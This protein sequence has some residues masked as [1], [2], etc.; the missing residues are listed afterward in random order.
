MPA[1]LPGSR[2][3]SGFRRSFHRGPGTV[4]SATARSES[5]HMTGD[6]W[7]L[8]L[9]RDD[10]SPVQQYS[11]SPRRL[12]WLVWS[13]VAVLAL[14]AVFTSFVGVSGFARLEARRLGRENELLRQQLAAIR[15]DVTHLEGTLG[16][17]TRRDAEMRQIAGLDPLE[18]DLLAVGVGGPGLAD[19]ESQPLYSLDSSLGESA[20]AANYDIEAL[21]R[22]ALLL[23]ESMAEATDSLEAHRDLL[24]ATPSI[25]PTA[26]LLSSRFSRARQHPLYHRAV[27]HEG[28]DISAPR[29][30]PILAAAKGK[31]T[32]AGWVSGYGQ[33]VE[34]AHG[35]GFVTRYGHASKLMVRVGQVVDRGEIIAQVGN[36]GI[37]TSSHLHYEVLVNGHAQNPLNYV[38]P[39]VFP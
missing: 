14:A 38:L 27:P 9:V 6:R 19:P 13:G 24:E 2:R 11:L 30:T 1:A 22:R 18:R 28:I 3:V 32:R 10:E 29:G 23:S 37:A 34:I 35:Y 4:L 39:E 25:L 36:S 16:D 7:T 26:G 33:M 20:F 8:L 17:L 15:N 5:T 12:R 31:V 21:N